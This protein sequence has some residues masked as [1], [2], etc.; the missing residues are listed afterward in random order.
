MLTMNQA[1]GT[2]LASHYHELKDRL[3]QKVILPEPQLYPL[4]AVEP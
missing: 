1:N 3:H 4:V 2:E